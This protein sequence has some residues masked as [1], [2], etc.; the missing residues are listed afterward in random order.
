MA[1]SVAQNITYPYHVTVS[2]GQESRYCK[3]K[4]S[5][6]GLCQAAI[7]E[8]AKPGVS[9]EVQLG[10]DPLSSPGGNWQASLPEGC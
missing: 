7:R 1:N 5:A 10:K 3:A 6:Q 4:Y 8:V 9:S 2:V